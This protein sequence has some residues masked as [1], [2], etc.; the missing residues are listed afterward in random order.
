[1]Q[2]VDAFS[3]TNVA[4]TSQTWDMTITKMERIVCYLII[5]RFC[6]GKGN[7]NSLQRLHS[8]HR[9]STIPGHTAPIAA[10]AIS[11]LQ[12][13]ITF[14]AGVVRSITAPGVDKYFLEEGVEP[15]LARVDVPSMADALMFYNAG[16]EFDI[17]LISSSLLM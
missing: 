11:G 17:E 13:T 9:C 16:T 2:T 3:A 10:N 14:I 8:L 4:Q 12:K 5:K 1:V 6:D 15:I 7:G